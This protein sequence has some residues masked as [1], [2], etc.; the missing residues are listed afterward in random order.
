MIHIIKKTANIWE[1]KVGI[2][3]IIANLHV[4][5]NVEC[6]LYELLPFPLATE[7]YFTFRILRKCINILKVQYLVFLHWYLDALHK[8]Y[9]QM[10]LMTYCT[11]LDH[12]KNLTF[13]IFAVRK[14]SCG[15]VIFSQVPL[16]L[17]TGEG[18]HGKGEHVWQRGC[19][20]QR[21]RGTCMVGDM[22]GACVVGACMAGGLVW[23]DG[24]MHGRVGACMTGG[25]HGGRC[26]LWGCAWQR[27]HAW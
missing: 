24:R 11:L 7:W 23:Q 16:I 1:W 22:V 6:A 19:A 3:A 8:G 21:G 12:Q 20:W 15:K 13:H 10:E 9:I 14:S 26:V 18:V 2:I 27:G 5:K 4:C 17:S 25:M